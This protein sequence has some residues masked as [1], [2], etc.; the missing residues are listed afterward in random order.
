MFLDGHILTTL[1]IRIGPAVIQPLRTGNCCHQRSDGRVHP[2]EGT[3]R[4]V[5]NHDPRLTRKMPDRF[6]AEPGAG[7]LAPGN[8][9]KTGLV[10]K[11]R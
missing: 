4:G 5:R 7:L 11:Y 3:D 6:Q 2:G 8:C 9:K 1:R 10:R